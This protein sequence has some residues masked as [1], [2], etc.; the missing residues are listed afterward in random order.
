MVYHILNTGTKQ[1]KKNINGKKLVKSE[2][3]L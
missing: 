1:N 2:L 3:K